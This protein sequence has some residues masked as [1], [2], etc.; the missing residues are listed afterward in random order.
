M[1]L[2]IACCLQIPILLVKGLIEDRKELS[3]NVQTELT[4]SWGGLLDIN[5]PE[6]CMPF[7]VNSTDKDGKSTKEYKVRKI[8]SSATA[9]NV[10]ADVEVLHRSIYEVLVYKAD[11]KMAGTF[12][13]NENVMDNINGKIYVTLPINKYKGLEGYP[14]LTIYGK[15]Y[16]FS[17]V[18]NE[19][20]AAIPNYHVG[21]NSI[22]EF[23]LA[24][25]S[26][27]M[28]KLNFS[29]LGTDYIVNITSNYV[30]PSLRA[31]SFLRLE[32]LLTRV[33]KRN[34]NLLD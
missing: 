28:E 8:K 13:T 34:G 22:T 29:P 7:Y 5:V 15:E 23:A 10:H 27:G 9:V 26:K 6:L 32:I 4:S 31:T 12:K 16:M 33:L 11:F 19:L 30:S 18:G 17:V 3:N 21:P 1:V 20:R 24:F 14:V 2:L 25:R